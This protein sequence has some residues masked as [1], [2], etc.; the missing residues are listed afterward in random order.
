MIR[1]EL[2]RG[3]PSVLRIVLMVCVAITA[4][5]ATFVAAR[6]LLAADYQALYLLLEGDRSEEDVPADP[7]VVEGEP[8]KD[9]PVFSPAPALQPASPATAG[10][11]AYRRSELHRTVA[12]SRAYQLRRHL[13]AKMRFTSLSGKVTGEYSIEG[14]SSSTDVTSLFDFLETLKKIPSTVS[15]SYWREGQVGDNSV[16]KF[17]FRG[18]F[19]KTT[20]T[21]LTPLD[22]ATATQLLADFV[23]QAKQSG[24]SSVS[25]QD[26]IGVVLAEG[27]Q[28]KRLKIWATGSYGLIGDYLSSVSE[29]PG[30]V[31]GEVVVVPMSE[32]D[33]KR[34]TGQL[35]AA[36]DV[37]VR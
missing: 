35:Y 20:D 30:A 29:N 33:S 19:D 5:A 9:E 18:R 26:P 16:Y 24:L 6:A 31:V 14:L 28:R 7:V 34:P 1:I 3:G 15:L 4:A 23:R 13:P 8:L 37:I 10:P 25:S 36:I 21:A 32:S 2:G 17:T 11:P 12:C 27:L 22:G